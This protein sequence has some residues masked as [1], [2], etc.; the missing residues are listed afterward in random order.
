[1]KISAERG[2]LLELDDAL[3]F[4]TVHPSYLLRLPSEADRARAYAAFVTDLR[5]VAQAI[6]PTDQ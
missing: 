3:V 6:E 5:T 4:I 1:V 2:R